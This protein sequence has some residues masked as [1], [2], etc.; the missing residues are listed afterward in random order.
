MDRLV[1]PSSLFKGVVTTDHY[2]IYGIEYFVENPTVD[3]DMQQSI[4]RS[5]LHFE[6]V[7]SLEEAP[8]VALL[9]AQQVDKTT[10]A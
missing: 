9:G 10:L 2:A 5:A 1:D 8:T 3:N 6:A 7:S 4:P